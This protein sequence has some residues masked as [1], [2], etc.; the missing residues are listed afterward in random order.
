MPNYRR[1]WSPGGTYFFTVVTHQL[2]GYGAKHNPEQPVVLSAPSSTLLLHPLGF[3]IA[4]LRRDALAGRLYTLRQHR[5]LNTPTGLRLGIS[6]TPGKKTSPHKT[7]AAPAQ[8]PG[9]F[10]KNP[11]S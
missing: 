6:S 3:L 4:L 2:V 9:F 5:R 1:A 11:V 10:W 8:I 7:I